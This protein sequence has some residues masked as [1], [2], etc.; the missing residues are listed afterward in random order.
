ELPSLRERKGDIPELARHFASQFA[1]R[2]H[3]PVPELAP[4]F[5]ADLMQRDWPGNVRELENFVE[6]VM[7]MREGDVLHAEML[8]EDRHRSRRNPLPGNRSFAEQ[9]NALERR[10][11]TE[12]L[13][14]S[15]GVQ[16]R[17]AH[18]VGLTES[19]RRYKV[20]K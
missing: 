4:D 18:E 12:A 3:R 8:D 6:R 16:S 5:L 15:G 1:A 20:S 7:T 2:D 17:A 13:R 10:L 9:V 14:R 19:T 11:L